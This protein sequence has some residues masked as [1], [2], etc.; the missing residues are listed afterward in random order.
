MIEHGL[1]R[2]YSRDFITG[3]F[4]YIN[5]TLEGLYREWWSNG[6]ISSKMTY[7]NDFPEGLEEEWD[8]NG[9]PINI[10]IWKNGWVISAKRWDG[11]QWINE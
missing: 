9:K 10:I 11:T 8:Q 4:N 6:Q 7:K 1:F 5:G 2:N 3:E